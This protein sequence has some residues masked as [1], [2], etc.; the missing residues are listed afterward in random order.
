MPNM[1]GLEFI[2]K[3][4]ADSRFSQLP[5]FAITADTEFHKDSRSRL[6]NDILL[7]PIT[8]GRLLEVF[9]QR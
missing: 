2:E 3:L 9:K 8:Y 7:K 4:R 5:V 1:N 6:F